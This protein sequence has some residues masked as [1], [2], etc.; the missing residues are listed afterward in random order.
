VKNQILKKLTATAL[1]L[2]V[3]AS[4]TAVVN[5]G[6]KTLSV[7]RQK[8][9]GDYT[10]W[11]S[12]GSMISAYLKGNTTNYENT[13]VLYVKGPVDVNQPSAMGSIYDTKSGVTYVTGIN[14]SAQ[15]NSLSYTAVKYQINNNGPIAAGCVNISHMVV[16][17]GYNDDVSQDVIYNDPGNGLNLRNSYN[18]FIGYMGWKDSLFYK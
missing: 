1:I 13:I 6:S 3:M 15:L 18:Y 2:T 5:A 12:S 16:I 10:C 14:G 4:S 17:T 11:A 8:Q 9:Q 7:P